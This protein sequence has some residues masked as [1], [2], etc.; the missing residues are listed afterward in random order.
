MESGTQA[1]RQAEQKRLTLKYLQ[2]GWS[3]PP[4]GPQLP[5]SPQLPTPAQLWPTA[6]QRVA[7]SSVRAQQPPTQRLPGQ[8]G[9]PTAPQRRQVPC[10]PLFGMQT[11]FASVQG[12]EKVV[13]QQTV[14]IFPHRH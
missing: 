7:P 8:Q 3:A 2:Q 10:P 6:T 11:K 9:S 5:V 1:V 4:H 14:P 13:T 12:G